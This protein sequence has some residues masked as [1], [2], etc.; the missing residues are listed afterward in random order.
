MHANPRSFASTS[1]RRRR[2]PARAS[3]CIEPVT[4]EPWARAVQASNDIT[5][6]GKTL[7]LSVNV[8]LEGA[9]AGNGS[10]GV[11]RS[12]RRRAGAASTLASKANLV[13]GTGWQRVEAEIEVPDKAQR[14]RVRRRRSTDPGA[15]ASTTSAW[16]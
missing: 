12:S 10:R 14:P 6:R 5:L 13:K 2:P 8:R 16:K 4:R 11:A 7:R 1:T 3:L 15:R 9:E